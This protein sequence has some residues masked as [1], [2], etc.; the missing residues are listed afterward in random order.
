[1]PVRYLQR[2]WD[3]L[4]PSPEYSKAPLS[5]AR[6]KRSAIC[7]NTEPPKMLQHRTATWCSADRRAA[8]I[9]RACRRQRCLPHVRPPARGR[10]WNR[11]A[12]ALRLLAR[13]RLFAR[14]CV[15]ACVWV[16]AYAWVSACVRACLLC[17][18]GCV[19]VCER[20]CVCVARIWR[21][22]CCASS[23]AADCLITKFSAVAFECRS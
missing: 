2:H 15:R 20:E 5:S 1:V 13:A 4:P 9:G 18:R 6:C 19:S 14:A 16:S 10:C 12:A 7:C 23:R 22:R 21:I 8:P 3:F 11:A 17:V